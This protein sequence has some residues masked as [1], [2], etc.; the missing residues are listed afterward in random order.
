MQH[1]WRKR[2]LFGFG[3]AV[4]CL[5]I[6]LESFHPSLTNIQYRKYQDNLKEG[7]LFKPV[8]DTNCIYTLDGRIDRDLE[9]NFVIPQDD[10]LKLL[11]YHIAECLF[12]RY[13]T[14]LQTYCAKRSHHGQLEHSWNFCIDGCYK[15]NSYTKVI[16]FSIRDDYPNAY[17]LSVFFNSTAYRFSPRDSMKTKN[18]VMFK[19]KSRNKNADTRRLWTMDGIKDFLK[20]TNMKQHI[21]I[22]DAEHYTD[23]II[24][25]IFKTRIVDEIHQISVRLT[26]EDNIKVDYKPILCKLR[27]FYDHGFRI[28][29]FDL[30]YSC[31]SRIDRKR[32]NC[33][34]IDM[35]HKDCKDSWKLF[36]VEH[37]HVLIPENDF[38]LKNM[39]ADEIE[40]FMS[41]RYLTSIQMHCKEI[42]RLGNIK[43]GGWEVCNDIRF[44]PRH[45]CLVYSF[46]INWDWGFDEEVVETYDCE[47]H[48]F[49]PSMIYS[50]K[51]PNIHFHRI[52]LINK[53]NFYD[54]KRKWNMTTLDD[55]RTTLGHAARKIDILKIDIEWDEWI[56]LPNVIK[57]GVL[58]YVTQ[59]LLEL[60]SPGNLERMKTVR[61]LYN[62][63]FRIFWY[64]RNHFCRRNKAY[65][66]YS[67]CFE[68][69]FVRI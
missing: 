50:G 53:R 24:T 16:A 9:G 3:V 51:R 26:N 23:L 35:I 28:F 38:Q 59:I 7:L 45:P 13:T 14:T 66:E 64:H 30:D 18:D 31:V 65:I 49:D 19:L 29:W 36:K 43:D 54:F 63:G 67:I 60:H 39:R 21:L 11:P 61:S 41:L 56:V 10:I 2:V 12:R 37:S 42:I 47:V 17:G 46:G 52:G 6:I 62:E 68:V 5:M 32:T 27:R 25:K 57:T 55:I 1:K 40:Q 33:M 15:P 69:C 8:N 20:S 58:K 22:I 48:S 34:Q 4:V 44:R